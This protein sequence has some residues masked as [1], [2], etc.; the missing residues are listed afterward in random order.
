MYHP[1]PEGAAQELVPVLR[2]L[3][4]DRGA[5]IVAVK[6]RLIVRDNFRGQL[7]IM[8]LLSALAD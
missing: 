7:R 4:D 3:A 6:G 1:D 8:K 5:V 2:E